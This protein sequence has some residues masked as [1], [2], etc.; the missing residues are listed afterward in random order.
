MLDG[1][2]LFRQGGHSILEIIDILENYLKEYSYLKKN[3]NLSIIYLI[4]ENDY[5]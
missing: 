2:I 1:W 3:L 4:L 5:T